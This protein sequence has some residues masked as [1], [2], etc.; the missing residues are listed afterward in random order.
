VIGE[1]VMATEKKDRPWDGTSRPVDDNYRKRWD[2]IF[3]KDKEK[4]DK[5]QQEQRDLDA[6]YQQSKLNKKE[7]T[8]NEELMEG[9]KKEQEDLKDEEK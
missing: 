4:F 6:S 1:K 8:L 3:G 7:R 5:L 9:F 2:E